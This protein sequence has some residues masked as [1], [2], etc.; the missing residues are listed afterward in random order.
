MHMSILRHESTPWPSGQTEPNVDRT[1]VKMLVIGSMVTFAEGLWT[2]MGVRET[3]DAI[4]EVIDSLPDED[5]VD[6]Y[7]A[8][9]EADPFNVAAMFEHKAR[10]LESIREMVDACTTEEN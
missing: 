1:L 2:R 6:L 7:Y 4:G 5:I 9:L 8:A 10:A 3:R